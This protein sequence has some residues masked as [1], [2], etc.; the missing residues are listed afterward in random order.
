MSNLSAFFS[1]EVLVAD[2]CSCKDSPSNLRNTHFPNLKS[3]SQGRYD[4]IIFMRTLSQPEK[5]E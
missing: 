3:K 4:I 2:Y 5:T 1:E